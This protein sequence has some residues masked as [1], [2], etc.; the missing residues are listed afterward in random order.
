[1]LK[2]G[3]L[4]TGDIGLFENDYLKITDRKKDIIVTPGGDNISPLK[5]ENEL[6]NSELFDQAMI[7]D[8]L[9]EPIG[10]RFGK[11]RYKTYALFTK[12]RFFRTVEGSLTVFFSTIGVLF[13]FGD[14]FTEK[15]F[16]YAIGLLPLS[17]M[18]TEAVS[19]HTW[20]GPFLS[21]ISGILVCFVLGLQ[22]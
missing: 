14:L 1:M 22:N 9:A 11:L 17:L 18:I 6:V 8:G 3:W 15:E 12:K 19:P 10:V 2:D 21:G 16:I 13:W 5:I 20:D 7:G 4:H